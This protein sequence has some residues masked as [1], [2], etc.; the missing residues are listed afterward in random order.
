MT[1]NIHLCPRTSRKGEFKELYWEISISCEQ[2]LHFLSLKISFSSDWLPLRIKNLQ[3]NTLSSQ[4][5]ENS[6][7]PSQWKTMWKRSAQY[8]NFK[9]LSNMIYFNIHKNTNVVIEI[10]AESEEKKKIKGFC[11]RDEQISPADKVSPIPCLKLFCISIEL[12]ILLV[13]KRRQVNRWGET[14]STYLLKYDVY[15]INKMER[16]IFTHSSPFTNH[17]NLWKI[18]IIQNQPKKKEVQKLTSSCFWSSSS[19]N[20]K[21]KEKKKEQNHFWFLVLVSCK[22]KITYHDQY[23]APDIAVTCDFFKTWE[24]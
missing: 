9:W 18:H 5:D 11:T 13:H 16:S 6:L 14:D 7:N 23:T 8:S 19:T 12:R 21:K 2:K 15:D 24:N 4:E 20:K 1:L 3:K 22:N 10:N 17:D